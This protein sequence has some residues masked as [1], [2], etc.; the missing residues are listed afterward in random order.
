MLLHVEEITATA[1]K[2]WQSVDSALE[3]GK[4]LQWSIHTYEAQ[5]N[6]TKWV[7]RTLLVHPRVSSK[8]MLL[9]VDEKTSEQPQ[10]TSERLEIR[11]SKEAAIYNTFIYTCKAEQNW[12]LSYTRFT[13]PAV[14]VPLKQDA[15]NC[16]GKTSEQR[17]VIMK[18][19]RFESPRER[20]LSTV[21][22]S[23]DL[24]TD[25]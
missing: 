22:S 8:Q 20:Q 17:K 24:T 2:T 15:S 3:R 19:W 23:R 25:F 12:Q 9:Q 5:Y 18:A 1:K 14:C 16:G 21:Y 11:H 4:N 7:I 10:R 6:P 13:D